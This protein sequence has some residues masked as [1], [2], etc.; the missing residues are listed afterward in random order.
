MRRHAAFTLIELLVVIGI[1]AVMLGILLPTLNKATSRA[2]LLR[3]GSNERQLLLAMFMYIADYGGKYPPNTSASGGMYWYDADRV[4]HYIKPSGTTTG[5]L[6]GPVYTCP[7]DDAGT[8]LSYS[9][10]VWASSKV[11]ASVTSFKP[12]TG[13]L[14]SKGHNAPSPKLI[15]LAE[16]FPWTGAASTGWYA[17]PYIGFAG[18]TAGQKFGGGGG[19]SPALSEGRFGKV[20]SELC[21]MRHRLITSAGRATGPTGMLNIGYADGHVEAKTNQQ[22]LTMLGNSSGDSFWSPLDTIG[23]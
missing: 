18:Y 19:I 12:P 16:A 3:C 14:W 23:P 9:M 1:V 17:Q 21:Y 2:K 6:G 7:S 15:V 13:T 10:N 20:V 4:G 11:D 8:R 22:V 5:Q